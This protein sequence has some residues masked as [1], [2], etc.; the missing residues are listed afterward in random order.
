MQAVQYTATKRTK[1]SRYS[2]KRLESDIVNKLLN[3]VAENRLPLVEYYRGVESKDGTITRMQW[4]EGLKKVLRLNIPF[5]Q[6]QDYFGL[7]KLGTY[8]KRYGRVDYMAFLNGFLAVSSFLKPDHHTDVKVQKMLGDISHMMYTNRFQLESLFRYFDSDGSGIVIIIILGLFIGYFSRT[9]TVGSVR[10]YCC[11]LYIY[12]VCVCSHSL[13]FLYVYV[14]CFALRLGVLS[15]SISTKEFARGLKSLF[16]IL[17]KQ[18]SDSELENLVKFIDKDGD[19]EIEYSELFS[20]FE[21]SD[22]AFAARQQEVKQFRKAP[23]KK[24][25]RFSEEKQKFAKSVTS[26]LK[27]DMA[28]DSK[29]DAASKSKKK[30]HAKHHGGPPKHRYM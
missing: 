11:C 21:M 13:M 10:V 23:A 22:P 15:G 25:Y 16:S 7:P 9:H 4:A 24:G 2:I 19:G 20:S 26:Q 6:F 18:F 8:G 29:E 1:L 30:H 27:K 5:L 17:H 28:A 14:L 12:Y 3:R